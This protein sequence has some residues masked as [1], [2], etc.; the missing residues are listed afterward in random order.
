MPAALFRANHPDLIGK[1]NGQKSHIEIIDIQDCLAEELELSSLLSL[2]D[3]KPAIL[4]VLGKRVSTTGTISVDE[5]VIGDSGGG[6]TRFL[7][8]QSGLPAGGKGDLMLYLSGH[9]R[10]HA[11]GGTAIVNVRCWQQWF[12]RWPISHHPLRPVYLHR[13]KAFRRRE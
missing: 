11:C 5:R 7:A 9:C 4:A 1:T 3:A 10:C 2:P 13:L 6:P 12:S 8:G